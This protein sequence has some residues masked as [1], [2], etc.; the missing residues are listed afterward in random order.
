MVIFVLIYLICLCTAF[1]STLELVSI[2]E[3]FNNKYTMF[4]IVIFAFL[5]VIPLL[6]LIP[7]IIY[8]YYLNKTK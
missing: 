8:L 2:S 7:I 1:A 6:N 3:I 5:I 4:I